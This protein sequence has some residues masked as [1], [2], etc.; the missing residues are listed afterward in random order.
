MYNLIL[1]FQ[2]S[3]DADEGNGDITLKRQKTPLSD[4]EDNVLSPGVC[5][6]AKNNPCL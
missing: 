1:Y 4:S 3:M 2:L 5:Y 6:S